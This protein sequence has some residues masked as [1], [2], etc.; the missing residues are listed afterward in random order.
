M[1]TRGTSRRGRGRAAARGGAVLAGVLMAGMIPGA[2]ASA[3]NREIDVEL[4]YACAF[5]SGEREIEARVSAVVPE[6][7]RAGEAVQVSEVNTE[8]ALP[9][10][11]VADLVKDPGT[12]DS[13][14]P[15]GPTAGAES[16]AVPGSK[17]VVAETRLSVDVAQEG[18]SAEAVWIGNTQ[19]PSALP[20]TG[21]LM[22]AASGA[23]P[24]V[25]APASGGLTFT[26]GQLAVRLTPVRDDGA[27]TRSSP[28]DLTCTPVA[29]Q[30]LLLAGVNI[31]GAEE[32]VPW[33]S[34]TGEGQ[35]GDGT[36][37]DLAAPRVGARDAAPAAEAPECLGDPENESHL[38]AYITGYAN[39]TKLK[40]AAK[41][42]VACAKILQ[43][44][45]GVVPAE[46]SP[47]GLAHLIQDSTAM[48]D[49]LGRPQ[50]PPAT[51]TFL[52]FGF[53]PTT[54]TMEMT[55]L[56][57]EKDADG[58]PIYNVHSDL[59]LNG[60]DTFG[61]TVITMD[62][63]LRLRDVEVNG[64]ALEVGPN[65]R[66]SKPFRLTLLG[67][68][69]FKDFIFTGY[70]LTGGGPLTSSV[71]VPPFS[72]CGVGEDLDD[73]F[74]ASISGKSGYV[75]QIQGPPC[76]AMVND[77]TLCTADRQPLNIPVA[78]R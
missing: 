55:Q 65:C 9:A 54:A 60:L 63:S 6:K 37:S 42:P 25:T 53:M 74:T 15:A 36:E 40:G 66:T 71:T 11:A 56:P 72:G 13:P 78:E 70:T 44:P 18:H 61:S 21:D 43:G 28:L 2:Q 41:F 34:E 52:T 4:A 39:V 19:G 77:E 33:P 38:V 30:D 7:G 51:T 35:G 10:D 57:L 49:Y 14:A 22:L 16:T 17:G 69:F 23:V 24:A 45:Q 27:P 1:T 68:V 67:R 62:F 31:G 75:K 8:L 73:L 58:L 46:E 32:T 12:T 76:A 29:D 47:D 20:G 59:T 3:G 48:V 50:L 5:P 26:A 64:V